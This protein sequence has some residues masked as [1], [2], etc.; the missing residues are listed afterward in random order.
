MGKSPTPVVG[1]GS[2]TGEGRIEYDDTVFLRDDRVPPWKTGVSQEPN[3]GTGNEAD[4]VDVESIGSTLPQPVL[5]LRLSG[6][7]R[8]NVTNCRENANGSVG[9]VGL[10]FGTSLVKPGGV[11]SPVG[12]SKG[13]ADA[14]RGVVGVQDLDGGLDLRIGDV[15]VR[16]GCGLVD[17]MPCKTTQRQLHHGETRARRNVAHSRRGWKL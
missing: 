11:E 4:G 14:T 15:S 1:G 16:N 6:A 13:E 12:A 5:H 17:H 8:M 7:T 3:P 2:S 10:R 9:R